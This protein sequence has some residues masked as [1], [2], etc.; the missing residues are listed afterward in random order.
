MER[1]AERFF[2]QEESSYLGTCSEAQ[3]LSAF[4]D[5]WTAKEALLK[6]AGGGLTIPLNRCC[7]VLGQEP[8]GLRLVG[9]PSL[10]VADWVVYGIPPIPGHSAALAIAGA[11]A[12]PRYFRW[13]SAVSSP[14]QYD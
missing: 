11:G 8:L 5:L 2:S 3:R 4:Y 1:I 10:A 14:S 6:G 13:A 7:F 9:L 12:T